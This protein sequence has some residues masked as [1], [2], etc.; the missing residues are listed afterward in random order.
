MTSAAERRWEGRLD[1]L[2]AFDTTGY[3][4]VVAVAAHPDDE[5]LGA[6]ACLQALH[7]NGCRVDVV[8]ASD[9]EAAFPAL[10]PQDRAELG[11]R[12]RRELTESLR[13]Q[14][15][16]DSD[17]HWL[18]LPDSGLAECRAE[19]VAELRTLLADADCCLLPW[20]HDP[21]PDHS[22]VGKAV[23]AAAPVTAHC[24]SYPIW[25]WHWTAEESAE[26]PWRHARAYALTAAQLG[27]KMA[28]IKAFTSQLERGPDGSDPILPPDVL[29]HFN[30]DREVLFRE[31]RRQSAPLERFRD[32]YATNADPWR[33]EDSWYERRKRSVL[34]AALP[35]E[36]YRHAVEPACGVGALTAQLAM[37]ADKVHAFDAVPKAVAAAGK[38]CLPNLTVTKA[39]LP[40]GFPDEVADL[41]VLSEILYYLSDE[42]LR[43]TVD[44][45][46]T[47]LAP[48]GD[49]VL[50]H[51]RPWAPEATRDAAE[52]HELVAG[53]PE[54]STLVEHRDEE[55][56]LHVLRRR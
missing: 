42:D 21:H 3:R 23:L 45:A 31:P 9:G 5:T 33:T 1:G 51:W 2:A 6:S 26:I 17:V 18:G 4:R 29:E 32:L 7:E 25:M 16:G 11:R 38:L 53:R 22:A 50:A 48:G 55:F 24:W 8:V 27:R 20:P 49:L 34:L 30:R 40:E 14:G 44:N 37:R 19:L 56:L 54:L 15:L 36:R 52:A 43:K 41:V 39:V 13:A 47:G 28:G 12:R 35:R 10:G 46:I